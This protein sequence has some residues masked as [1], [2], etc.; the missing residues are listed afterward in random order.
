MAIKRQKIDRRANL[1]LDGNRV[2]DMPPGWVFTIDCPHHGKLTFDF[3]PYREHGRENLA[4]HLRDAVWNLRHQV[5]GM[6]LESYETRGLRYFYRFLDDLAATG[7]HISELFQVDRLLL[8]RYLAWMELQIVRSGKSKGQK[9]STNLKKGIYHELKA[10]LINRQKHSPA[11][12][13]PALSFPRN[14]FPNVN[15]LAKKRES[16]SFTEQKQILEALNR[17]LREIH[18]G[19]TDSLSHLQVLAVHLLVLALATGRNPQSLL[20]LRRNSLQEHPLPDRELLITTK[21]RGWTTHATS[22]RKFAVA[23][24]NQEIFQAIPSTVGEHF[25]FLCTFTAPL[26]DEVPPDIREFVFLWRVTHLMRRGV[27]ERLDNHRAASAIQAFVRRHGL[28]DDRGHPLLLNVSRCRPTFATELYRRTHDIRRVQQALG[29]TRA[30]TTARY[31]A[32]K[33]LSAERDHSMLLDAMTERY[34]RTEVNGKTLLAADGKIPLLNIEDILS[35]GYN[36]AVARCRNPFREN[37]SSCGKY[38]VCFRCPSQI[39]FED[40][41]WRLFSFYFRLLSEKSKMN[42]EHWAKTYGPIIRRIDID[43]ASQFP[44]EVVEIAR[45]SAQKNPHPSWRRPLS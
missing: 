21:R 16:Y 28:T 11:S 37:G 12:A 42:S 40:D 6:T 36:T 34:T 29:H 17:D 2:V 38:L 24:D 32:E 18:E 7:E 9:W 27:V 10:L 30:E 22:I 45:L 33:P 19:D 13:N 15:Q 20:D 43:I 41:L 8:E 23:P 5:V 4:G 3:N 1:I 14:A 35:G 25:R 31:Y 39:V 44:V 26:F